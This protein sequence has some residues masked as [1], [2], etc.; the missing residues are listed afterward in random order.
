MTAEID[1]LWDFDDPAGSERRFRA[2]AQAAAEPDRAVLTTQVARALGL[3]QRYGDGLA[4]LDALADEPRSDGPAAD[5][6]A[7]RIALERGRLLRSSGDPDRARPLFEEAAGLA[8]R[9]GKE[10][11]AIDALHMRA[12]AEPEPRAAVL[13]N[14]AALERAHAAADPEARRWEASLL[15]N[16]GCALVDAGRLEEALTTFEDAVAVRRTR[17]EHRETQIGRWMVAWTLRLLGRRDEALAIQRSLEAEL[18]R[19]GVE[20]PYVDDEIALLTADQ[21]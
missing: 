15:N 16:L 7:A 17:N 19:D 13:L 12:L 14:R 3:Q 8:E 9:A 2:A 10:A 5:H 11:L 20:D 1:A 6:V 21:S 18:E 4:L